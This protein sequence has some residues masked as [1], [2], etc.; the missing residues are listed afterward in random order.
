MAPFVA[1]CDLRIG[2]LHAR[3]HKDVDSRAALRR[4]RAAFADLEMPYWA[5]R[6]EQAMTQLADAV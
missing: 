3:V 6:A 5:A 4:A 2:K 1:H